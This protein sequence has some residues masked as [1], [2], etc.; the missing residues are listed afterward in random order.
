MVTPNTVLIPTLITTKLKNL[1]TNFLH[2]WQPDRVG[3]KWWRH[4]E[5]AAGYNKTT[6]K[7]KK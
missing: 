2:I 6:Y 5:L 3:Q 1:K 7:T 4:D